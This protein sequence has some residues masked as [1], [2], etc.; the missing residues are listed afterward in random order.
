M[1]NQGP[2]TLG[3]ASATA[4]LADLDLTG[5]ID[6]H[7]HSAPDVA[8]RRMDDLEVARAAASRGMRAIVLKSH[9]TLTS[10]RAYLVQRSVPDL[11][12]LGGIVLNHPVGG[13]NPFAVEA[14][15]RMGAAIVWMPTFSSAAEHHPLGPPL[16]VVED[17]RVKPEVDEIMRLIAEHDAVLATGHLAPSEVARLVPAA[18]AA[19]VRRIVVTHPEHPPVCMDPLAQEEFRDRYGVYFERCLIATTFGGG[20]IEMAELV[21]TIRRVGPEST[22][23]ATDFGQPTNLAPADGMAWYIMQLLRL[24]LDRGAVDRIS[25]VNGAEL[26]GLGQ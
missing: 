21:A 9:H 20:S 8:A 17:G 25:R 2:R 15:L 18:R 13:L 6:T 5:V 11:R 14:A 4:G 22:V 7:V 23:L 16:S 3:D 19:G 12:V 24:G 26:L 1:S 10:D